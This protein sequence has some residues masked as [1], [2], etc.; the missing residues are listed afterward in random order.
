MSGAALFQLALVGLAVA[1]I[2]FGWVWVKKGQDRSRRLVWVTLFLTFDLILFGAFTRLT[3]SGLGCP[4]WPG[5]YGH[6][7]PIAAAKQIG[8]AEAAMPT[9]PV[10]FTKA[11][12]EMI[13]RYLAMGVGALIT[14]IM[15]L[16]WKA[17]DLRSPWPATAIFLLVCVQGAFG[18]WTVTLKLMPVIVTIHLLLGV[19]L[20]CALGLLAGTWAARP[21]LPAATAASLR[22]P[23]RLAL[24]AV[25]MQIALGGWV[26]TNYAVLACQDFPLCNGAWVPEGDFARG[27]DITRPLGMN[28]DGTFLPV[29]A[30]VA[31]HWVHR[32]FALVVTALLLWLASVIL[33]GRH[34]RELDPSAWGLLGLLALQITSGVS[35]VVFAWPLAVAIVHNGGAAL[36]ALTLVLLNARLIV[37]STAPAPV[38]LHAHASLRH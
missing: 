34:T 27:F 31:I 24:A 6:S 22:L 5:C 2:P 11:W 3:D 9:G 15:V 7:N 35:N 36:L 23:A 37:P 4:D 16:A 18:A 32:V 26:S 17:R 12:I 33:R 30:L 10:T 8:A 38:S 28:D 13:H 29:Q 21:A 14:A 20:L 1:A 25:F 19:A